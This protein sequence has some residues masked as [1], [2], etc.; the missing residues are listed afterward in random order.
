MNRHALGLT[1]FLSL[2]GGLLGGSLSGF[3]LKG[4]PATAGEASQPGKLVSAEE[5]RVVDQTGRARARLG[6]DVKGVVALYLIDQD[7]TERARL[8]IFDDL[9]ALVLTG[10]KE[11][12]GSGLTVFDDGRAE[13]TLQAEGKPVHLPSAPGR[14]WVLWGQRM[15]FEIPMGTFSTQGQCEEQRLQRQQTL[16]SWVLSCLPESVEPRRQ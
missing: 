6:L 5:F 16:A 12:K 4:E 8:G 1:V 9:S 11:G 7:G 3:L 10:K 13:L 2:S 15:P 14:H